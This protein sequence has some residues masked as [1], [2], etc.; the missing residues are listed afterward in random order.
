MKKL[1]ITLSLLAFPV[2]IFAATS[3]ITYLDQGKFPDWAKQ[4]IKDVTAHRLMEGYDDDTFRSENSV[5]RAE[6]AVIL[7]RL[8]SR[9]SL[10]MQ[11]YAGM[12]SELEN[13]KTDLKPEVKQV[14]ALASGGF[15]AQAARPACVYV[16]KDGDMPQTLGTYAGYTVYECH[17]LFS[18]YVVNYKYTGGLAESDGDTA[19]IDK[20]FGPYNLD[21]GYLALH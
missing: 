13:A 20:W 12:V 4:S 21:T 1:L 5:S 16:N 6:L 15:E 19:V 2:T 8:E 10:N 7:E 3:T 11:K 17:E 9:N 14:I 18:Q